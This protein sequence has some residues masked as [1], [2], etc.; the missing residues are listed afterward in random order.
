[1]VDFASGDKAYRS[2]IRDI[3]ASGVFIESTDKFKVGQAIALCFT[4]SESD[5]MLP[6][7]TKG[8]VTRLYPDGIGVQYENISRYQRDI[9]DALVHQ[10]PR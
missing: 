6:F 2:C 9:L 10:A 7:K 8:K 1:M 4:I 5:E 3:S